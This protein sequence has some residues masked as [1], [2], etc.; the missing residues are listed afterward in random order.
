MYIYSIHVLVTT[1][2]LIYI[3]TAFIINTY[4]DLPACGRVGFLLA[5]PDSM[6]DHNNGQGCVFCCLRAVLQSQALPYTVRGKCIYT[7]AHSTE[8]TVYCIV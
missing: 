5:G 8:Y 3:C 2:Q 7:Y 4:T 6:C 1:S